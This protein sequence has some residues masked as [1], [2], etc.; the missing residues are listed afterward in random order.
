[1]L[2]ISA[3]LKALPFS[4]LEPC[5]IASIYGLSSNGASP[6][7]WLYEPPAGQHVPFVEPVGGNLCN[8]WEPTVSKFVH[9]DDGA[10]ASKDENKEAI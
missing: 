2:D 9:V 7:L 10:Q 3:L 5:G 4:A 1:M 8:D 6:D